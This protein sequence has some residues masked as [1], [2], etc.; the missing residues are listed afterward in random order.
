MLSINQKLFVVKI[1]LRTK[2][3]SRTTYT[4][5]KYIISIKLN[6]KIKDWNLNI[7]MRTYATEIEGDELNY[8]VI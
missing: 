6:V 5:L 2:V 4:K 3:S 7:S 8:L 1:F